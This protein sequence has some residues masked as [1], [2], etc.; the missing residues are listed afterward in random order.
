MVN[1]DNQIAK[2]I[3]QNMDDTAA[4]VIDIN[5]DEHDE[6]EDEEVAEF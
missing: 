4:T 6:F 3:R 5:N 2:R 1:F